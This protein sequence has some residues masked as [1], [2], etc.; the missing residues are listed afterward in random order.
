[1]IA[2]VPISGTPLAQTQ[3][4]AEATSTSLDNLMQQSL[5]TLKED[6]QKQKVIVRCDTL[7]EVQGNLGDLQ[8]V[9]TNILNSI[10]NYPAESRLFIYINYKKDSYQMN[11]DIIELTNGPAIHFHSNLRVD[12]AWRQHHAVLLKQCHEMLHKYGAAFVISDHSCGSLF[13]ISFR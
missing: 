5:Q 10:I 1:M 8:F 9:F 12:D 7:P 2:D 13:S 6:I 11:G 3:K 4:V